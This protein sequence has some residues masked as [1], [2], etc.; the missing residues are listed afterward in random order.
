MDEVCFARLI[1]LTQNTARCELFLQAWF[2]FGELLAGQVLSHRLAATFL[3]QHVV[4][5]VLGGFLCFAFT[6]QRQNVMAF[7]PLTEWCGIDD[8]DGILYQGLG[9]HQF[10]VRC[11]VDDIDDTSL[12]CS[13]FRSP[14]KVAG[15]QTKG[16]E[17]QIATTSTDIMNATDANLL[18][19]RNAN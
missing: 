19:T 10:V 14:G 18:Q 13:A 8:N 12:A 6:S 3:G 1:Q 17:F 15:V 4:F 9:T 5:V 16:T 7:I 11:I 2:N